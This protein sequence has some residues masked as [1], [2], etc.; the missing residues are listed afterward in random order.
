MGP[1]HLLSTS[2][3][4]SRASVA[5]GSCVGGARLRESPLGRHVVAPRVVDGGA[6]GRQQDGARRACTDAAAGVT[7]AAAAAALFSFF[8][9]SSAARR[10]AMLVPD[11]SSVGDLRYRSTVEGAAGRCTRVLTF[12]TRF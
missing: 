3:E 1:R 12:K 9:S 6:R 7:A 10:S 8:L 2:S 4:C 11:I 5:A